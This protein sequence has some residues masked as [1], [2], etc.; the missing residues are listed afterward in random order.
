M[1]N[2]SIILLLLLSPFSLYSQQSIEEEME[3]ELLPGESYSDA[4]IRFLNLADGE[5]PAAMRSL[6]EFFYY[7]KGVEKSL[8]RAFNWYK[9]AAELG[10]PIAQ[11]SLGYAYYAGE[12]TEEDLDK[13]VFWYNK[14]IE[15]GDLRAFRGLAF[16]YLEE[17]YPEMSYEKAAQL[18]EKAI[19]NG[20]KK[21]YYVL[22]VMYFNGM[23]VPE[24]IEKGLEILKRGDEAGDF[25]AT[26][27]LADIYY[28]GLYGEQSYDK[29][30][31]LY[32]KSA[33]QGYSLAQYSLGLMYEQGLGTDQSIEKAIELYRKASDKDL[34]GASN[35]LAV[36]Y[37]YGIGV[38]QSDEKALE[39]YE[40][41]GAQGHSEALNSLGYSYAM[42]RGVERSMEKANEY[43]FKAAEKGN[44][45]SQYNLGLNYY[46]GEGVPQSYEK[47]FEYFKQSADS[48]YVPAMY[49]LAQLYSMGIGV[50]KSSEKALEYLKKGADNGSQESM[51]NLGKL[52]FNGEGVPQSY[53]E[54]FLWFTRAAEQ[55]DPVAM[56]NLGIMYEN[57]YG[58]NKSIEK[59]KNWFVQSADGGYE[60]A[61]EYLQRIGYDY[62]GEKNSNAVPLYTL[63]A[64][65]SGVTTEK[66]EEPKI[67]L[68]SGTQ[69]VTSPKYTLLASVK[70]PS[71][72]EKYNVKVNG[73]IERGF[74]IVEDD[75]FDFTIEKNI[76]LAQGENEI[77]VEVV[78]KDGYTSSMS[79][80]L[81]YIPK[82]ALESKQ[83]R[84]ALIIGNGSYTDAASRL[85]N[86]VNDVN[87]LAAKLERLN[88]EVIKVNDQS[89]QGMEQA[90]HTFGEKA[91]DFDV[92]MFYYA[93]HGIGSK[94]MNFLVPVD[95]NMPDES[96]V[97]YA[98]VN[99]NLILDQ[100]EAA[101]CQMKIV[102]LDACRNNPFAR[103]W[104]RGIG[105][106]GLANTLA[107]SG[108]FLF[109]STEPGEVAADGSS[110]DR[111]SPFAEAFLKTLDIPG[112]NIYEFYQEVLEYVADKTNER[113]KPWHSGNPRGKFYFNEK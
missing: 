61:I 73:T 33:E 56:T 52:Y 24:S 105:D 69:P 110:N 84:I 75:G 15:G 2:L 13:A 30:F 88:F 19:E 77:E 86:P 39:Y 63:T 74:S 94:G 58:V 91:K 48:G 12:G 112:L 5:D 92:A 96:F 3:I 22:A 85:K 101:G 107:P 28:D 44:V 25:L 83:K 16:C 102:V 71:K 41:A 79:Y 57:G 72:V 51:T 89:K 36:L 27:Y 55:G 70:S 7:G 46:N 42:G 82:V 40:K 21:S 108:T 9:K 95:A 23:G 87:D 109:Y 1:K 68:L 111:N 50:E 18:F 100:I 99:T 76:T 93:G 59:A 47:S 10:D 66:S 38:E 8:T 4:F 37:Q 64:V 6:G 11:R 26:N 43:Y 29:A 34:P 65:A 32:Q 60:K 113:Q 90:I 45:Y 54:A 17:N 104:H 78:N 35:R 62:N 97:P 53:S 31:E 106:R 49:E 14:A 20:D 81:N 98:C 103:S 67:T 80:L